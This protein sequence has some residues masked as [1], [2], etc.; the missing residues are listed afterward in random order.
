MSIEASSQTRLKNILLH[1]QSIDPIAVGFNDLMR[2]L[3]NYESAEADF[4]TA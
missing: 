2:T 4:T 1:E 3:E